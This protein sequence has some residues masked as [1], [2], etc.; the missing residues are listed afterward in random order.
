MMRYL[1]LPLAAVLSSCSGSSSEE[2]PQPPVA[3]VDVA[4]AEMSAIAETV[5]LYGVVEINPA[6]ERVLAAPIEAV[7]ERIDAPVGT[8]VAAGTVVAHLIASPTTRLELAKASADARVADQAF[9][10]AQRLRADGLVG[11]AEVETA[12][13]AALSAAAARDSL[14]SRSE[15]LNLKSPLAGFVAT[16]NP[17]PGELIAAGS[18]V[19]S[20]AQVGNV[21]AH[22][23]IEPSLARR[24]S[25]DAELLIAPAA[26]GTPIHSV[27]VSVSPVADTQTKLASVFGAIAPNAGLSAGLA[28][29]ASLSVDAQTKQAVTVPY[30]ALLD[31]GG[32]PFVFVVA[33]GAAHRHDVVTGASGQD[34]IAILSG[35]SVGDPV[36]TQGGTA[37]ED[38]MKVR[39]K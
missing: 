37:V 35:L 13:A 18:A 5:T 38:G 24:V 11:D 12:R 28:L 19:A 14:Q 22:L 32:Q 8:R 26:G 29:R 17:H 23:G 10:R 31:D 33:N 27:I 25:P 36:V 34:R 30:A 21:R 15:L 2:R 20:I 9:A 16:I 1:M 6:A 39:L 7:L 3:L 4:R